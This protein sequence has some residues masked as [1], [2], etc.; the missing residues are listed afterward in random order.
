[1]LAVAAAAT[2]SERASAFHNINLSRRGLYVLN[3][4]AAT[5]SK[6]GSRSL[7][8][9]PNNKADHDMHARKSWAVY[10]ISLRAAPSRRASQFDM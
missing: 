2:D 8:W 10:H 9:L 4:A 3:A 1:M 5:R 6:R 7:Y